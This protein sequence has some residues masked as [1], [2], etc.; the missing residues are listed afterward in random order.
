MVNYTIFRNKGVRIFE[1]TEEG[2]DTGLRIPFEKKGKQQLSQ[3]FKRRLRGG[4]LL[5][6]AS[7]AFA[8]C[9][10]SPLLTENAMSGA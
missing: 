7:V 4:V 9:L 6:E 1:N 2:L 10:S 8:T 3:N 5:G